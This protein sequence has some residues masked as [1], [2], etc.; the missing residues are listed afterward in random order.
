M[1][2]PAHIYPDKN[3]QNDYIS[4]TI[5]NVSHLK[6]DNRY[7]QMVTRWD[8]DKCKQMHEHER[9]SSVTL[10]ILFYE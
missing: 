8:I 9:L 5:A 7:V 1:P 10:V 3:G 6:V 4:F 2:T